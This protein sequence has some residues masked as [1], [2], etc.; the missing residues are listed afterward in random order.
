MSVVGNQRCVVLVPIVQ[1]Q[2]WIRCP[3]GRV[4][5]IGAGCSDIAGPRIGTEY[6][7]AVRDALVCSQQKALIRLV[8][9]GLPDRN[10]AIRTHGQRITALFGSET[11]WNHWTTHAV[12]MVEIKAAWAK[13]SMNEVPKNE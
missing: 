1:V 9:C 7:K 10:G 6:L 3:V 4:L 5:Y 13:A 12:V 11:P 2:P 8:A